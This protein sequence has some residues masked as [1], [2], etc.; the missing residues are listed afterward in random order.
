MRRSWEILLTPMEGGTQVV[1]R[2]VA[3]PPDTSPF[4]RLANADMAGA[5]QAEVAGN[6]SR[7]KNYS[8][9]A[10]SSGRPWS[11]PWRPGRDAVHC[12]KRHRSAKRRGAVGRGLAPRSCLA[13]GGVRLGIGGR[14]GGPRRKRVPTAES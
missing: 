10:R 14:G 5:M 6:L 13:L 11:D 9:P 1:Q 8:S 3:A 4:A 12:G 7:L 2:G